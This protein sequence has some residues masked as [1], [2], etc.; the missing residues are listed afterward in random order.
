[1]SDSASLIGPTGTGAAAVDIEGNA[2][3]GPSLGDHA[4]QKLQ[5]N[6]EKE[7]DNTQIDADKT[8]PGN[9]SGQNAGFGTTESRQSQDTGGAVEE[10]KK[11][12]AKAV[13]G[14]YLDRIKRQK[15]EKKSKNKLFVGGLVLD[16]NEEFL[17]ETFKK[18]GEIV[19]VCIVYE[20]GSHVS[21]GFGY[22][23][24]RTEK[25]AEEAIK[26]VDGMRVN[27]KTLCV[28]FADDPKF[29]RPPRRRSRSPRRYQGPRYSPPRDRYHEKDRWY[30]RS[31]Y[32]ERDRY[33]R[34]RYESERYPRNDPY[35][36]PS[37]YYHAPPPPPDY[38]DYRRLPPRG[39]PPVT[40]YKDRFGRD[41]PPPQA[42]PSRISDVDHARLRVDRERVRMPDR[43]E[44]TVRSRDYRYFTTDN[45]YG[46]SGKDGYSDSNSS[47]DDNDPKTKPRQVSAFPSAYLS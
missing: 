30:D 11:F 25:D 23:T 46:T 3:L 27:G 1:M 37:N 42:R 34:D 14:N 19:D 47:D 28:E 35:D 21:R 44:N 33:A 24:F 10:K 39:P 32:F 7:Y 26:G 22:V 40:E 8:L 16:V 9:T 29:T 41:I 38:Y 45:S 20:K 12:F 6:C 4:L 13:G 2:L 5:S 18:Y 31:P 43:A 17:Q 36:S 15:F